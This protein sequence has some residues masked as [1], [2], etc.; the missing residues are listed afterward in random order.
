M[1]T[2]KT[3]IVLS[4]FALTFFT[5][6]DKD[7]ICDTCSFIYPDSGF[8]GLNILNLN[9]TV[10][11]ADLGDGL[12]DG[13]YCSMKASLPEPTSKLKVTIEGKRVGIYNNQGWS[14][15]WT[16]HVY[17]NYIFQTEGQ[18]FADLRIHFDNP[19]EVTIKIYENNFDS[20]A[21]VKVIQLK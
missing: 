18:I 20:Y 12:G 16:T 17:D 1:K 14:T 10:F 9:D 13:K 21:R 2:A 4:L 8:H 3:F 6:C 15:N 11:M 7:E 5:N 19:G